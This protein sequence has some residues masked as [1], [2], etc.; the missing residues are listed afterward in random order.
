[1]ICI[2]YYHNEVFDF[3]HI[4]YKSNLDVISNLYFF[5][6]HLYQGMKYIQKLHYRKNIQH[7]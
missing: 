5:K 2:S 4:F 7:P 1:M 6:L 3:L